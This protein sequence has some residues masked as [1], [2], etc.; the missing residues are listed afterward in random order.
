MFYSWSNSATK[1]KKNGA[2][3]DFCSPEEDDL[4]TE[5]IQLQKK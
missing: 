3:A 2:Q 1:K 4:A 5:N